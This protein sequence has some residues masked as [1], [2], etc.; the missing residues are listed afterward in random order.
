[1]RKPPCTRALY[2]NLSLLKSFS[3]KTQYHPDDGNF[4]HFQTNRNRR[5][6]HYFR[7]ICAAGELVEKM[8]ESPTIC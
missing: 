2:N 3:T 8:L 7:N 4:Q 5:E 1:M 6:E